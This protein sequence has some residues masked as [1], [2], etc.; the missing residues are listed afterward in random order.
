MKKRE[1]KEYII[2]PKGWKKRYKCH[3]L[4][5]DHNFVI[6]Y[7]NHCTWFI[8]DKFGGKHP[9]S[10]IFEYWECTACGKKHFAREQ[11]NV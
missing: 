8:L 10:N 6:V 2:Q 5:A 9:E 3:K 1:P 4:K 11:I 7:A